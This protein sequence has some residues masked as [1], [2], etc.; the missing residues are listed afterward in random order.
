MK[1]HHILFIIWGVIF[2]FWLVGQFSRYNRERER[3]QI[4]QGE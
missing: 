4:E 2:A 3:K 1:V